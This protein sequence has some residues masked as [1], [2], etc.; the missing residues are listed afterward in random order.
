MLLIWN[1]YPPVV[2]LYAAW[3]ILCCT[4]VGEYVEKCTI[5][6]FF[7]DGLVIFHFRIYV[8]GERLIH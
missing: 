1:C 3:I 8:Y 5:V 7:L 4:D 6:L 2:Y